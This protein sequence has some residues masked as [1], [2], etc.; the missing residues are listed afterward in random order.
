MEAFEK[1]DKYSKEVN[2]LKLKEFDLDSIP[3]GALVLLIGVRFSGKSF[4][5]RSLMHTF[6]LRGMPYGAIF[7]GTEH[8]SPFFSDYFPSAFIA[9]DK[10]FTDEKIAQILDAQSVK[11][12][13]WKDKIDDC[14]CLH[15]RKN[16]YKFDKKKGHCIHNNM[17]L[18][19]DDMMSQE[20]LLKKSENYKKIF[21]E[22][23]HFNILYLLCINY[24]M[25]LSPTMRS[26]VDYVFLYQEE[27]MVNVKKLYENYAGIFPTFQMFKETLDQ[28]TEDYG[29]LVLNKRSRSKSLTD[30]VFHF[31]AKDPGPF[32]FGNKKFWDAHYQHVGQVGQVPRSLKHKENDEDEEI[33]KL[34]RMYAGNTN[35]YTIIKHN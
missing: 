26:N 24:S 28:C 4:C 25:G 10:D 8:V 16:P 12:N 34:I 18:I 17:L 33:K 30:R 3:P 29:C 1:Y 6:F 20:K 31:K 9:N 11:C 5:V 2:K 22:G 14:S 21:V 35:K 23:R 13:Y 32:K 27:E 15:C 19:S 7:S